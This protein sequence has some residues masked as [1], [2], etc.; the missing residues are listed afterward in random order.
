MDQVEGFA[1]DAKQAYDIGGGHLEQSILAIGQ[2]RSACGAASIAGAA[3]TGQPDPRFGSTIGP[4]RT[5]SPPDMSARRGGTHGY[6]GSSPMIREA[7]R[8]G[9]LG[10][11]SMRDLEIEKLAKDIK[12]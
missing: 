9:M 3:V 8:G 1:R 4:A 10:L 11:C 5:A 7:G 12:R 6:G 2:A